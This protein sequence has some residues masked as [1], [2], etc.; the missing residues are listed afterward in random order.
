MTT[1]PT[2]PP[3]SSWRRKLVLL[4]IALVVV[5]AP[6]AAV[7]WY[8]FFRVVDQPDRIAKDPA[9]RFK[10]GS[11]GGEADTGIPYWI[12]LVLPRVFPDLLPGPGGYAAFGFA[13]EEG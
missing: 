3:K 8:K 11:F 6:I 2:K 5:V 1:P 9:M 12:W 10:Y 13:W 4:A 7:G